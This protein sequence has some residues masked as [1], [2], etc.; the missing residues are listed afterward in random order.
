VS[1][2]GEDC[3]CSRGFA[4]VFSSPGKLGSC[5]ELSCSSLPGQ[6]LTAV[7]TSCTCSPGWQAST[8]AAGTCV[9]TCANIPNSKPNATQTGCT[10][11]GSF[12]PTFNA[13][14]ALASCDLPTNDQA[15]PDSVTAVSGRRTRFKPLGNDFGKGL[16]IGV[17]TAPTK[18]GRVVLAADN[19]T[20]IY[21]SAAGAPRM[22][23]AA[24]TQVCS[25]PPLQTCSSCGFAAFEACFHYCGLQLSAPAYNLCF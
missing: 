18:G 6:Q 12:K 7:G 11:I 22:H 13:N 8:S 15:V 23:L 2:L 16:K 5:M 20:I 3:V 9:I 24:Q 10:C 14:G 25:P 19:V 1:P 17:V 4:E 21:L